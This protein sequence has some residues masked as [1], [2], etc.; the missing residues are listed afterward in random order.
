MP[1]EAAAFLSYAR[2]DAFIAERV[3]SAFRDHAL[4]VFQDIKDLNLGEPWRPA[5]TEGIKNSKTLVVLISPDSAVSREVL[6]EIQIAEAADKP[7]I[8]VLVRGTFEAVEGPVI[9]RLTLLHSLDAVGKSGKLGDLKP[10]VRAVKR[11][12]GRIAPVISFSNLKGGVGKTTLAA[13]ISSALAGRDRFSILMIDLDPQANLTQFVLPAAKHAE[14]VAEDQSVLS[15]FEK[16][17]VYGAPSPRSPLTRCSPAAIE[18]PELNRIATKI[19]NSALADLSGSAKQHGSVFVVPGQF[20]LVKYT[21]PTANDDLKH[22]EANFA[23]A[24]NE[25]RKE[26]DAVIIDLNPSSSFM[27]KCAL[28][29]STHIVCPIRPDIYSLK[30]LQ[31]LKSLLGTA[32]ALAHPPKIIGILNALPTWDEEFIPVVRSAMDDPRKLNQL[33]EDTKTGKA[34]KIVAELLRTAGEGVTLLDTHIPE[35]AMLQAYNDG[36]DAVSFFRLAQH[37]YRGSYGARLA[38]RLSSVAEEVVRITKLDV[39]N[40][41]DTRQFAQKA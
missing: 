5:L 26:Y 12:W 16:S 33:F 38:S 17:L 25:A 15:L 35:T 1:N 24:I 34:A 41:A 4:P 22:L 40:D 13:Q 18:R 27:I 39:L 8:P 29:Y 6:S 9:E 30:G 32:F 37:L 10:L 21:L 19:G 31:G 23:R 2:E 7:I 14:L 20:E 3:V 36:G 28:S 11:H